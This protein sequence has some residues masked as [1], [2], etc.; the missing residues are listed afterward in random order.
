MMTEIQSIDA[1]GGLGYELRIDAPPDTVWRFL[2]EPERIVRWM[3]STATLDP[4]AGGAF[5]VDYGQGDIVAGEYIEVDPP[6]RVVFSWGWE[7]AEDVTQP[8]GSR[9]EVDLEPLDGGTAT[10]LRLRHL[11]LDDE[12]RKSHDEGWRYFLPRLVEATASA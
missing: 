12:G 2:V 5:R 11:G 4:R 6:R 9:V 3:G 8:G 7:S 10:R 1:P